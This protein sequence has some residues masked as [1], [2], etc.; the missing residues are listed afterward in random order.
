MRLIQKNNNSTQLLTIE[1]KALAVFELLFVSR[2]L[3][4]SIPNHCFRRSILLVLLRLKVPS[5]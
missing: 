3:L 5:S 2:E 4:L 1:T